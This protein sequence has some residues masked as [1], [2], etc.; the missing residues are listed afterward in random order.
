MQ[1][2]K[3]LVVGE[4]TLRMKGRVPKVNKAGFNKNRRGKSNCVNIGD[5]WQKILYR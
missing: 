1:M 5:I 4:L 2:E 3:D